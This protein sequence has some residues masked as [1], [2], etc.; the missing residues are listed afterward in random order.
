MDIEKAL[1]HF[2]DSW[3]KHDATSFRLCF[4]GMRILQMSGTTLQWSR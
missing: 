2:T 4:L 3:N 1:T